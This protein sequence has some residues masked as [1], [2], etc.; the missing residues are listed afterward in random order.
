MITTVSSLY[1]Y[2]RVIYPCVYN[3]SLKNTCNFNTFNIKK[4]A[5]LPRNNHKFIEETMYMTF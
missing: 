1:N 2:E 5:G 4:L 3:K